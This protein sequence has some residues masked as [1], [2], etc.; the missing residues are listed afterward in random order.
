MKD[1]TF[2]SYKIG[3]EKAIV[4]L[5]EK[6]FKKPMGCT[7][8]LQ[9]WKW[10]FESNSVKPISVCLAWDGE[11]LVGQ[12]AVNPIRVWVSGKQLLMALSLDTMTDP[13]YS[14]KGIFKKAALQLYQQLVE[15]GVSFVFGFPNINSIHGF[16]RKLDWKIIAVPPVYLCPITFLQPSQKTSLNLLKNLCFKTHKLI[17][18]KRLSRTEKNHLHLIIRKD[19]LFDSWADELWQKCCTQHDVWAVRDSAYLRWRYN[20]RPETS[21]EY[22]TAW[23]EGKIAGYVVTIDKI[24]EEGPIKFVLDIMVDLKIKGVADALI[25]AVLRSSYEKRIALV[26]T[27]IMPGSHYKMTFLKNYFI[28]LPRMLFPQEIYFGAKSL[29]ENPLMPDVLKQ[30]S[31]HLCWGDTDLL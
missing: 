7:D 24:R 9:H 28:P 31:W 12:Y 23:H 18:K 19:V 17:L 5:F 22:Y 16:K 29:T 8:S 4:E 6:V 11:R 26:S 20:E 30:K 14:R 1:I 3:D 15:Q 21:Y 10:E 13:D 2:R 25:A 27:I